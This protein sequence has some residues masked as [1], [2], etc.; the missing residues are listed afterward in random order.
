MTFYTPYITLYNLN[1]RRVFDH[2]ENV[3]SIVVTGDHGGDLPSCLRGP[4]ITD[5]MIC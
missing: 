3:K 1:N 2:C 4:I 5:E